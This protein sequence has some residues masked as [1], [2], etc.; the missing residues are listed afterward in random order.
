MKIEQLCHVMQIIDVNPGI[1][2]KDLISNSIFSKMTVSSIIKNLIENEYVKFDKDIDDKRIIHYFITS[3]GKNFL[4]NQISQV[5]VN[6]F[7]TY[8]ALM[9]RDFLKE[10]Q[11]SGEKYFQTL[12]NQFPISKIKDIKDSINETLLEMVKEKQPD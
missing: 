11:L 6:Q 10:H 4:L 7:K 1:I 2:Q 9:I 12:F 8:L 3:K 5:E